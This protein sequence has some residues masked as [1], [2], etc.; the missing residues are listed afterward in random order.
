M[1]VCAAL[2]LC[3]V[4]CFWLFLFKFVCIDGMHCLGLIGLHLLYRLLHW[5]VQHAE[6]I[7][8]AWESEL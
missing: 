8:A 5:N 2:L 1:F 7:A 6:V 4:V 3:F